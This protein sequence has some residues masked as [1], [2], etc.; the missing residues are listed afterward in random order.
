MYFVLNTLLHVC[1]VLR[2]EEQQ[3]WSF[4]SPRTFGM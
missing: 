2:E 4:P 3:A 1:Q